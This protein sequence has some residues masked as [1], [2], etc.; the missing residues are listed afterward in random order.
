MAISRIDSHKPVYSQKERALDIQKLNPVGH[1]AVSGRCLC[2]TLDMRLV[3]AS[4]EEAKDC[5]EY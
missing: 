3:N 2:G 4:H 1:R 5:F